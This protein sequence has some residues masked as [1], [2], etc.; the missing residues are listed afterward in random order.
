MPRGI[1]AGLLTLFVSAGLILWLNPSVSP[2]SFKLGLS[3]EPLLDGFRATFGEGTA[4]TLALVAC[5][6]LIASF[7]TILFAKGRQIYS[8][9][10][11]GYFPRFLS[12]TQPRHKTPYVAL[13]AGSAV[14]LA[15]MFVL[16]FGMGAEKGAVA[17]QGMLLNMAVDKDGK[18]EIPEKLVHARAHEL[19][20]DTFSSLARRGIS[21]E[22][23]LRIA[24]KDEET[25]AH[26]A[27]P[28]A[29]KALRREALLSAVVDAEQIQPSDED[30]RR[31]LEPT[32]ERILDRLK[33]FEG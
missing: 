1:I 19:L 15:I 32:A 6:G 28:E 7:H 2:G 11:A 9:S 17:I 13:L 26:E 29:E 10:R 27:E 22:M 12:I 24:G 5:V 25:L 3:G 20:E 8:L 23:Y 21:K 14:A 30:I 4:K 31:M 16:W 18:L 33:R